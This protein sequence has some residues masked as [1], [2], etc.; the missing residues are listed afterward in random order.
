MTSISLG[1][2]KKKDKVSHIIH[3]L[4]EN[5]ELYLSYRPGVIC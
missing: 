1:F 2:P 3:D 4:F 5:E